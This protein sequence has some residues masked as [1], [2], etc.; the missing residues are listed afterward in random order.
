M[1]FFGKLF[2][3]RDVERAVKRAKRNILREWESLP[4][5]ERLALLDHL[6]RA[7]GS[8]WPS[9]GTISTNATQYRRLPTPLMPNDEEL[10]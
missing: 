9:S 8:P 6:Y 5:E 4:I 2:N 7:A 3:F 10:P 1:S